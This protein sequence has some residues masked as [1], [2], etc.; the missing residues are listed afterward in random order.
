MA[1]RPRARSRKLVAYRGNYDVFEKTAAERLRNQRKA[2]ESVAHKKQHMQASSSVQYCAA[3]LRCTEGVVCFAHCRST[4][5]SCNVLR[6]ALCSPCLEA[7]VL[8]VLRSAL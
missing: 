8:K 6:P 7:Y 5:V 1:T 2:A 3:C 4:L